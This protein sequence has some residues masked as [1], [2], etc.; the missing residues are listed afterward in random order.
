MF[1]FIVIGLLVVVIIFLIVTTITGKKAK[2]KEINQ[3]KKIVRDEI[4]NYIFREEKRKNLRVNFEQVF[5]RKGPDYKY[6]DVF[7]V[8]VDIIEPK[9]NQITEVK[10]YEIEGF[11]VRIDKKNTRIEWTVNKE[12]D[13][14]ETRRRIAIAEKQ[15]KLSKEE[16]KAIKVEEVSL[17]KERR[18]Q[19]RLEYKEL[20]QKQKKEKSIVSNS[21]DEALKKTTVKF[22]PKRS[23]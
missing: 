22:V 2:K 7:D 6:R 16:K 11:P 10:A 19:E 15:V 21:T 4:K 9:T 23:K 5:A 8:I 12:I 18:E 14:E 3:R 20:K 13:I 1:G 17:L